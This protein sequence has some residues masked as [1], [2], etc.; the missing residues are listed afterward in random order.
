MSIENFAR[1]YKKQLEIIV[2]Y[3]K[4]TQIRPQKPCVMSQ[5]QFELVVGVVV[6][7]CLDDVLI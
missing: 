3:I 7:Q 2:A 1:T 4:S 6:Y 5:S